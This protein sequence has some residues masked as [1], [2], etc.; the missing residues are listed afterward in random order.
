MNPWQSL[1]YILLIHISL[2]PIQHIFLFSLYYIK[3]LYPPGVLFRT[4]I[5]VLEITHDQVV[6]NYFFYQVH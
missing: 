1:F 5:V 3:L 6:T 2:H 4:E